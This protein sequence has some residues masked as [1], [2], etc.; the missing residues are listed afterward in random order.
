MGVFDQGG[1][2]E[3]AQRD[4][5]QGDPAVPGGPVGTG[6]RRSR[7]G[8]PG[9]AIAVDDTDF[10]GPFCDP[11][12]NGFEFHKRM[13]PR[14]LA[15]YG[16]DAQI[17]RKLYRYFLQA[18]IPDPG[19]HLVQSADAAGE[20]KTLALLTLQATA[21]AIVS[22]ALTS[23]GEVTAGIEDLAAFTAA[24]DTVVSGPAS[25]KPGPGARLGPSASKA[26]PSCRPAPL[27]RH[28]GPQASY[29]PCSPSAIGCAP[30]P[31]FGAGNWRQV[32][33]LAI[34]A[35]LGALRVRWHCWG[36]GLLALN[37]GGDD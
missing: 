16:G 12:N 6:A 37:R 20:A 18:G 35:D 3:K 2:G 7:P 34:G 1:D 9:G 31:P 5:G 19:L 27:T 29:I 25:S 28:L 30:D 33:S 21:E 17:G 8:R 10:D 36:W 32:L 15:H 26:A 23:A 11:R 4:H 24:P 14:L 22:P 13:Y